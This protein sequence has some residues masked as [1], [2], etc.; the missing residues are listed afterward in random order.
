[1]TNKWYGY[2]TA[3]ADDAISK[4]LGE[5]KS[6]TD[7]VFE[8]ITVALTVA[9]EA[10]RF[11][12]TLL[13]VIELPIIQLLQEIID[14][15]EG[16]K[17]DL[18]NAGIYFTWDREIARVFED[19]YLLKGGYSAF[20]QR[21]I[22]K[23]SN[24]Q[25]PTRPNF[26]KYSK[27]TALV[28]HAGGPVT[29]TA[30]IVEAVNSFIKLFKADA[31]QEDALPRPVDVRVTYFKE[32]DSGIVSEL[33]VQDIDKDNVPDGIR[34]S[35]KII[36]QPNAND[37]F[38]TFVIPP[39]Y[40]HVVVSS[41]QKPLEGVYRYRTK[42]F[43]SDDERGEVLATRIPING[44]KN[45][46][47]TSD[48][49][50]LISESSLESFSAP[51]GGLRSKGQSLIFFESPEINLN[52]ENA[53]KETAVFVKESST[54]GAFFGA[55][56]Y[57]IDLDKTD[58]PQALFEDAIGRTP[59][60]VYVSVLSSLTDSEPL[61]LTRTKEIYADAIIK[62]SISAMSERVRAPKI[63]LSRDDL[64]FLDALRD[65]I[66]LFCLGRYDIN[67]FSE[68]EVESTAVQ[69]TEMEF[70]DA[71]A[72]IIEQANLGNIFPTGTLN[73]EPLVLST[74][75][76][77]ILIRSVRS[78]YSSADLDN[79]F[80]IEIP[81]REP[82]VLS[83]ILI[84]SVR[85]R[86]SSAVSE[87]LGYKEAA[88]RAKEVLVQEGIPEG[89]QAE[90]LRRILHEVYA[91][92][93]SLK[94]EKKTSEVRKL[95]YKVKNPLSVKTR[96]A[97]LSYMAVTGSADLSFMDEDDVSDEINRKI[98]ALVMR[99]I[100]RV[101][102]YGQPDQSTLNAM[103]ADIE[104]MMEF[105]LEVSGGIG[106]WNLLEKYKEGTPI[107]SAGLYKKQ[108]DDDL[109]FDKIRVIGDEYEN[110]QSKRK[111]NLQTDDVGLPIDR[112]VLL[113]SDVQKYLLEQEENDQ[114]VEL[115]R[116]DSFISFSEFDEMLKKD[117]EAKG[118]DVENLRYNV[119]RERAR[120][121]SE[122]ESAGYHIGTWSPLTFPRV[123]TSVPVT[124]EDKS[125]SPEYVNDFK[126]FRS[127][128]KEAEVLDAFTNI[129]QTVFKG[130]AEIKGEWQYFRLFENGIPEVDVFLD[131]MIKFMRSVKRSFKSI[132]EAAEKYINTL[133]K[134]ILEIQRIVYMLK[135]IIDSILAFR[136]NGTI[137]LLWIE[138]ANGTSGLINEL[139][140]SEDK[141]TNADTSAGAM[142][143]AGGLPNII[144]EF[145]KV[146]AN[147]KESVEAI[148]EGLE[149]FA[150][151][152]DKTLDPL[153]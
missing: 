35:W 41:R 134:R 21:M 81:G 2:D 73:R 29:A 26:S 84:R 122:L 77:D 60:E 89:Y 107:S 135:R 113:I 15:M 90:A 78:R 132:I 130:K 16:L 106:V 49:I 127:L 59:T 71:G 131:E 13:N 76:T 33:D 34:V 79:I 45:R 116:S 65:C 64:T 5:V 147:P 80:S 75:L 102:A 47:L 70:S 24:T 148:N 86:Y 129:M 139:K 63:S 111:I 67:A 57:E 20:E 74:L 42:D 142:L 72:P 146:I 126:D 94:E 48:M 115:K 100:K 92:D 101:Y 56:E 9:Q 82:I 46:Y 104:K 62:K 121:R 44:S 31:G 4:A 95:N 68:D 133:N 141:P 43:V 38:P 143:V 112:P 151:G 10:L 17:K 91:Y 27:T 8:T 152:L 119:Q 99:A 96:E 54:L 136:I 11:L 12:I 153:S 138:S 22:K 7:P 1:M 36:G 93:L 118:V 52:L 19:P 51:E 114:T 25:D 32:Y 87:G 145:L 83:T 98:S 53:R 28:A 120:Y 144:I 109:I 18:Q 105:S 66:T 55:N 6:V 61:E 124:G 150:D 108:R 103:R 88:T 149:N 30:N 3:K 39:P 58:L 50:N 14:L 125:I 37:F 128:M 110:I 123:I 40:F 85:S 140:Q 69:V 97:V 23:L 117:L 137:D